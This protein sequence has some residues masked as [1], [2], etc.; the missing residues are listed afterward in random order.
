METTYLFS[1]EAQANFKHTIKF[2]NYYFQT[3]ESEVAISKKNHQKVL[4]FGQVLHIQD[5]KLTLEDLVEKLNGSTDI[6]SLIEASKY[7]LGR[8]I[9]VAQFGHKLFVLPD[10]TGSIP[11]NYYLEG[12]E[13][14]A[15]ANLSLLRDVFNLEVSDQA[16]AIKKGALEQQHPMPNDLTMLQNVKNVLPNHYLDVTAKQTKRYFPIQK[17][18]ETSVDEVINQTSQIIGRILDEVMG[19]EKIAIPLTSGF[20]SRLILSFFKDYT[21]H[22]VAY[23][24]A[25]ENF[26]ENTADIVVPKALSE[27]FNFEYKVLSRKNLDEVQLN[28][29]ASDLAGMQNVRILE[30]A[31]TLASS[32]LNDRSFVPGDIIPLAKSNFGQNLP[33]S[34]ASVSYLVTKSHN[35]SDESRASIKSWK[36]DLKAYLPSKNVSIYDLFFWENR[37]GRW[38]TN[39]AQNYDYFSNPLYIFNNR[40]LIELWLGVSRSER[41]KKAIHKGL[42]KKQWPELLE[43]PVNPD[44]SRL[45]SITDN[46]WIYYF[47]SYLKHYIK[48]WRR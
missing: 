10:A 14:A 1:Q 39:N 18:P 6:D 27:R 43:I 11:V 3:N 37:W 12:K 31:Y 28:Q 32:E 5:T 23:T 15:S 46:Q 13:V 30:N 34:L 20:D 7:L 17:L 40:Y 8:F 29:A 45:S 47:G 19:K 26:D 44:E 21:E 35:Y 9:I 33:D 25:H 38:F 2:E 41:S 4:L 16:I 42:I 22:I 48:G 36:D 24:F